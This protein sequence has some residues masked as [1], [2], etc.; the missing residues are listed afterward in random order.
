MQWIS[1]DFRNEAAQSPVSTRVGDRLGGPQGAV[2]F[3]SRI[4]LGIAFVAK[5]H[6]KEKHSQHRA[7][8]VMPGLAFTFS[9]AERHEQSPATT[10]RSQHRLVLR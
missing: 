7:L 6:D 1:F 3:A 4:R 5:K 8:Y 10:R 2:S 9:P